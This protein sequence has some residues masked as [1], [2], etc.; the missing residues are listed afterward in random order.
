MRATNEA[1]EL[2]K[3][4]LVQVTDP[5]P[6]ELAEVV[7]KLIGSTPLREFGAR[8][9]VSAATLSRII[10]GKISKPLPVNTLFSI[11]LNTDN[12]SDETGT[13]FWQ[14]ARANGMM[15]QA[16]Q[17]SIR[18][19]IG[20]SKKRAKIHANIKKMMSMTLIAGLAVRGV[21][22]NGEGDGEE[23]IAD[24]GYIK[25]VTEM[26]LRYDFR[27]YV[28]T[29]D[30]KYTWVLW[31][32]PQSEEDYSDGSFDPRSLA[33]KLLRELS[34]V[35]LADSWIPDL[36]NEMKLSFCFVDRQLFE[37]FCNLVADAKL[38]NRYSAILVDID[39]IDIKEERV[40][41]SAIYPDSKSLFD[42]PRITNTTIADFEEGL[43][44][45]DFLI[46]S[47]NRED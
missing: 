42:M 45:D 13:L 30:S 31:A 1:L 16:E 4:D 23:Y 22:I 41:I 9:G 27:F 37:C 19:Y 17:R 36:Y 34:P 26:G 24:G 29:T 43:S 10:N 39:E 8:I 14:L 46:Y 5:D 6:D 12:D 47:D 20:L 3:N 44:E 33:S 18:Q 25:N 40:F 2:I 35:F 11:V 32:F 28:D 21:S 38:N 15:S 7:K